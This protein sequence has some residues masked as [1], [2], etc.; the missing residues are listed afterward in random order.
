MT[1]ARGMVAILGALV[2]FGL[3]LVSPSARNLTKV[4]E[5][6]FWVLNTGIDP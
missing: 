2:S 3:S 4:L 6:S 5:F 1:V